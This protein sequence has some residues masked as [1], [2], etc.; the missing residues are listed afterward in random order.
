MIGTT[1]SH[2]NILEKL[3]EGGMGVVYK[4]EDTKLQR[5]VAIKVLKPEA[6]GDPEAKERFIREARAASALNHPNITTIHEIDE[7]HGQDFICMEYVEGET[8][9]KKIQSGPISIDEIMN[10]AA[11]VGSGAA[12]LLSDL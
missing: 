10:I 5:T 2:Y 9:K 6:I 1:I 12:E 7:W 11:Q 3:G 8:I 4:S